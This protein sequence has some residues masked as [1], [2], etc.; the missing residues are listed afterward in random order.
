MNDIQH[1]RAILI[2]VL[3]TFCLDVVLAVVEI[4]FGQGQ[5]TIYL[6]T[7]ILGF[8]LGQMTLSLVFLMRDVSRWLPVLGALIFSLFFGLTITMHE[9]G[10][11][12][13]RVLVIL[14]TT[15]LFG[16]VPV[17]IY[18]VVFVGMKVQFSLSILFGLMTLVTVVCAVFIQMDLDWG[19]F[20]SYF[21]FFLSSA[22]PIP[23]AAFMLVGPRTAS[24]R[25]FVMI[26]LPLILAC[27]LII[28]VYQ[29]SLRD[30]GLV[31]QICGFMSL[32]L[33]V[34]GA[35]LLW[36]AK[37]RTPL[38]QAESLPSVEDPFAAD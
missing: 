38:P 30:I 28:S 31:V 21:F 12:F 13:D 35:V 18:R 14:L 25:W 11:H 37:E 1:R 16:I 2:L 15:Q 26:M 3:F 29:D 6:T 7:C 17:A 5:Q 34:G 9:K 4:T 23:L 36:E 22:I 27:A 32:Y 10:A 8:S 20:L 19:W 24:T 33:L